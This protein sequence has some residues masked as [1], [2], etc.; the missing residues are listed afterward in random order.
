MGESRYIS[1]ITA[2]VL[3][4]FSA[5][6]TAQSLPEMSAD[7]MIKYGVLPNGTNYYVIANGDT[8]G[9]VDFALVH[10]SC[11]AGLEDPITSFMTLIC[12]ISQTPKHSR[13]ST[14]KTPAAVPNMR[15]WQCRC[16]LLKATTASA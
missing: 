9:T 15:A 3:S 14:I 8:K 1:Y 16:F 11:K 13:C 4:F 6:A 10:K 5:F 12:K 2:L 7:P